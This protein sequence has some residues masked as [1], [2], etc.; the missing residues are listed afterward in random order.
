MKYI[1]LHCDTLMKMQ[2]LTEEENLYKNSIASID[3]R[4]L[5]KS[6]A[7]AQFF[8]IFLLNEAEFKEFGIERMEDDLYID[9]LRKTLLTEIERNSDII[10]M[11]YSYEDLIRNQKEDKISAFISIEDGRSIDGK[12]EK[13]DDYYQMGVRSIGLTWNHENCIGYPNS[14]DRDIM[15][16]G[17]KDFGK[18]AVEYM[19]H[20]G[21]IIDV[22]HLNDGGFYDVAKISKK[23]FIASHS[24]ARSLAEHSRNLTDDMIRILGEKGGVTGLNFAPQFLNKDIK[25]RDSTIELMIKHL[26][27]IK[28]VGGEDVLALGTDFDGMS[29]NLEIDS[30]E[31]MPNLFHALSKHGWSDRLLEKFAYKNVERVIRDTIK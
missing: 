29:G 25:N 5:K 14:K 10:S 3:F 18:E 2:E 4:R 12:L 28:N 7:M 9:K 13:I 15:N 26:D 19:N 31:K 1:D 30:S 6:K 8:A 24:N 21:I 27:H 16:R 22:S 11:A 23:P 17:L 20:L